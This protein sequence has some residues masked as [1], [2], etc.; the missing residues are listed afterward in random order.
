MAMRFF[1][2]LND[3]VKA[4]CQ[5]SPRTL[6]FY[7]GS[8]LS[9]IYPYSLGLFFVQIEIAIGI[10]FVL[11]IAVDRLNLSNFTGGAS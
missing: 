5:A 4:H 11:A 9:R 6:R 1:C 7:R 8:F 3:R 2:S 10:E